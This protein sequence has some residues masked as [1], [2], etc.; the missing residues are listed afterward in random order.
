MTA[1]VVSGFRYL[2][3]NCRSRFS[4][5]SLGI[6]WIQ[7]GDHV[8]SLKFL[9]QAE[10]HYQVIL[11]ARSGGRVGEGPELILEALYTQ[12]CFY[13]A[14]LRFA[15]EFFSTSFVNWFIANCSCNKGKHERTICRM[16]CSIS[17]SDILYFEQLDIAVS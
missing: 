8:Q 12:T 13:L 11:S 9:T 2:I 15:I 1:R 3:V 14:Q 4:L 5:I 10:Q 17:Y 6:V 16:I 7:R